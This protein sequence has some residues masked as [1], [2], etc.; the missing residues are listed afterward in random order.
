MDKYYSDES[1]II[2]TQYPDDKGI[3]INRFLPIYLKLKKKEEDNKINQEEIMQC[4]LHDIKDR[5]FI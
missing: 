2:T 1:K 4:L 3:E 5:G